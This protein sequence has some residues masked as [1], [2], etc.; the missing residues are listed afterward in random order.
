[1]LD[2]IKEAFFEVFGVDKNAITLETTMENLK[3][4]DSMRHMELVMSLEN[5]FN[6]SFEINEVIE[7]STVQKIIEILK[8]K[9]I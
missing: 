9:N 4:W 6:I 3:E 8:N 1:M 5:K 7:L 2:K